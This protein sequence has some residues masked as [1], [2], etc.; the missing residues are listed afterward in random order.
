MIHSKPI[1]TH[2][3]Y[4]VSYNYILNT[5]HIFS[6]KFNTEPYI[7][8]LSSNRIV[9]F[10]LPDKYE[11]RNDIFEQD[12]SGDIIVNTYDY[13]SKKH[14]YK[15]NTSLSLNY[16]TYSMVDLK[17]ELENINIPRALLLNRFNMIYFL[18]TIFMQIYPVIKTNQYRIKIKN[19]HHVISRK[20]FENSIKK[21]KSIYLSLSNKSSNIKQLT[22]NV[23]KN[24]LSFLHD[25]IEFLIRI[26]SEENIVWIKDESM[27]RYLNA[28]SKTRIIE[29]KGRF[30]KE[31]IFF[32]FSNDNFYYFSRE[33]NKY[34]KTPYIRICLSKEGSWTLH[35][36]SENNINNIE[37]DTDKILKYYDVIQYINS[38]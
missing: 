24:L 11:I 32:S 2:S 16:N 33:T 19:Y 14:L 20:G 5:P 26:Q 22:E 25:T 31:Y 23:L 27:D 4:P 18:K 38:I 28:L 15:T 6:I 21:Q 12:V 34:Y 1:N 10:E 7:V 17:A 35:F 30:I 37:V 9:Y 36:G 8:D 3:L 13:R 29:N